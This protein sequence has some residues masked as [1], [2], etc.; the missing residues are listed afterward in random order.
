LQEIYFPAFKASVQQGGAA[1][2]MCSYP[3]INGTYA[4]E[5]PFLLGTLKDDWGFLGFVGPDAA[6]A[7]RDTLAA[8]NAG[9]DNFLLGGVGVPATSAL[10]AGSG[11]RH[12]DSPAR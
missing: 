3:R 4:C 11:A 12:D 7:V 9:T 8:V 5:N 6:L 10:P 2:V 1:S